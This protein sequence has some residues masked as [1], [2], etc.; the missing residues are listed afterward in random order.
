MQIISGNYLHMYAAVT[1][2]NVEDE[3]VIQYFEAKKKWW[4]LKPNDFDAREREE[5]KVV[6]PVFDRKGKCNFMDV[7][8]IVLLFFL[9]LLIC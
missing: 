4:T 9:Y 6:E 3:Y 2:E 7:I 5:M 1:D 8:L